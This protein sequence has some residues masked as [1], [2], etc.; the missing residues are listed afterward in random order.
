MHLY[1]IV[2]FLKSH[3]PS[4]DCTYRGD[5]GVVGQH[6]AT[7]AVSGLDVR[8]LTGQ[9]H[10][11]AGRAP[12]DELGQLPLPDPLQTLVNLTEKQAIFSLQK[13]ITT[14]GS[15]YICLWNIIHQGIQLFF[16]LYNV[17]EV[18]PN[19]FKIDVNMKNFWDCFLKTHNCVMPY[20][21]QHRCKTT[22]SYDSQEGVLLF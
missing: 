8:R 15:L 17:P 5:T 19:L 18:N 4:W 7:D 20:R 21:Y 2:T 6:Q 12:G 14:A 16:F 11:D 10:L 13:L 3:F 1:T 9:R 22:L